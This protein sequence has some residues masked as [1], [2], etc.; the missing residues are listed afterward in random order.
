MEFNIKQFSKQD[1]LN[2]VKEH[3][4]DGT[5][6]AKWIKLAGVVSADGETYM[7]WE[8]RAYAYEGYSERLEEENKNLKTLID[9]SLSLVKY[10][11]NNPPP[12]ATMEGAKDLYSKMVEAKN[13]KD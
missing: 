5:M 12:G 2:L 7:D 3:A 6:P 4:K 9:E 8:E 13:K 1:N 10:V 11:I